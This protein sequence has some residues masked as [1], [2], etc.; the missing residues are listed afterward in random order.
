MDSHSTDWEPDAGPTAGGEGGKRPK[1]SPWPLK[2][3]V[4]A[5]SPRE[6]RHAVP[7]RLGPT[8]DDGPLPAGGESGTR[9]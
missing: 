5:E 9:P 8:A 1:P 3:P 2:E 7:E 6:V 4:T